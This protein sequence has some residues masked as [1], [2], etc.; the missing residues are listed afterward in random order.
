MAVPHH[1]H[2]V[3]RG[4]AGR[5]AGRLGQPLLCDIH[6]P[7]FLDEKQPCLNHP[8]EPTWRGARR[9]VFTAFIPLKVI[10]DCVSPPIKAV[11]TLWLIRTPMTLVTFRCI[12]LG[13]FEG[14]QEI[15]KQT[16][17]VVRQMLSAAGI[18]ICMAA[19]S[20]AVSCDGTQYRPSLGGR[21]GWFY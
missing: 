17:N 20:V 5:A 16:T 7:F 6:R 14:A 9:L 11:R 15:P 4:H 13:T 19:E 21:S 12:F 2:C 10:L 8:S 18:V 1:S 3:C